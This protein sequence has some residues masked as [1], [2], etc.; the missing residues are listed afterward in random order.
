MT[1]WADMIQDKIDDLIL[2]ICNK[3]VEKMTKTDYDILSAERADIRFR[4]QQRVNEK[5]M[6]QLMGLSVG[7]NAQIPVL[8]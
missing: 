1:D 6:E 3:H 4:E 2:H 7:A 8:K 5:Q